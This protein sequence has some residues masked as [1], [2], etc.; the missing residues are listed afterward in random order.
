MNSIEAEGSSSVSA[1]KIIAAFAVIYIVWGST[2]FFIRMA[3]QTMPVTVMGTLRFTL[4]GAIMLAWCFFNGERLWTLRNILPAFFTGLLLLYIGN[5]AVAWSEQFLASSLVAVFVASS[6]M[7]FV[8]LDYGKWKENFS[9]KKTIAGIVLGFAGILLLFSDNLTH[10][11]SSAS[12]DSKWAIMSLGVLTIGSVSWAAGS[13]YGKYKSTGFSGSLNAGWQMLAAGIAY[14][15]TGML[16]SDWSSFQWREVSPSGWGAIVY[17]V[18]MGSLLGYSAFVWL[19]SVRP[20]TQVSTHAY[21]NP[22]IAVM[23]GVFFAGETITGKQIAG[24]AVIL[25]GVLLVNL[26]KYMKSSNG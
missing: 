17:L 24:L 12:N 19:L 8:L 25:G 26:A 4:A 3:V 6:P 23:L 13:L 2:F 11:F 15:F 5:G 9:S 7:W 10:I 22:V 21:V 16:R 18:T 14:A 20:A 1:T